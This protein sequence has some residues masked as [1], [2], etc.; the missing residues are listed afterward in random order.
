VLRE[1]DQLSDLLWTEERFKI[2]DNSI[3]LLKCVSVVMMIQ[4]WEYGGKQAVW[5]TG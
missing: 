4:M 1:T 5:Q 2:T 3:G